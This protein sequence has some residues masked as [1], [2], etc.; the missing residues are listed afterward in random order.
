MGYIY[1]YIKKLQFAAFGQFVLVSFITLLRGCLVKPLIFFAFGDVE[2]VFFQSRL[3]SQTSLMKPRVCPLSIFCQS[4]VS[5]WS[6]PRSNAL[7]NYNVL[8]CIHGGSE[9]IDLY[10][11]L[12][13]AA[14]KCV[15]FL[16]CLPNKRG[17]GRT[18]KKKKLF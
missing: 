1:I 5:A 17:K 15:F 4:L 6:Q 18:T 7:T 16:S 11:E 10:M 3:F 2:I 8:I 14:N 12:R 13:E 9:E